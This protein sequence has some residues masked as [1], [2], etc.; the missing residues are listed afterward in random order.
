M[1]RQLWHIGHGKLSMS[2]HTAGYWW[3]APLWVRVIPLAVFGSLPHLILCNLGWKEVFEYAQ[4][5]DHI[6]LIRMTYCNASCILISC[7][8]PTGSADILMMCQSRMREK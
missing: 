5:E 7:V 3:A 6:I 4:D 2:K 8:C 1:L